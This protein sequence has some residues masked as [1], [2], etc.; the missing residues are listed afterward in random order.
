MLSACSLAPHYHTPAM[1][2]VPAYKEAGDWIVAQ[3][4][5]DAPR[6]QWWK[7][8]GN[9]ELNVLEDKLATSN[10]DIKI[11]LARYEEA[12]SLAKQAQ[13]DFF[14]TVTADGHDF[15][16]RSSP[17]FTTLH[18]GP[19]YNDY[20]PSVDLSYEIDLWGRIR[21]EVY[22]QNSLAKASFADAAAAELSV[23][24]ELATDYFMLRG[25]DASQRVLDETVVAYSKALDLTRNRFKG[26]V[27]AEADLDQAETQYQNARTQDADMHMKRQQLEHAIAVLIGE[28]PALF[29]L[30]TLALDD[31]KA[32]AVSPGLP[33][34][35]LQRRPDIAA[36]QRRV[37]AA[38][39]QIGVARAAWFPDFS[40]SASY[41]FESVKAS[42][43]LTSASRIWSFGPSMTLPIFEAGRISGLNDQARA[44]YDESVATYRK[45]VLTAY[46]DVEDSLVALRQLDQENESQTAATKAAERALKQ[47]QD[48][49]TG[50]IITYLDVVVLQNTELQARLSSIDITTR[51]MTQSVQLVK[52][53][54]GGWGVTA[55]LVKPVAVA[56]TAAPLSATPA[57][58]APAAPSR[59]QR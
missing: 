14:P 46:Q 13:A 4:A 17:N 28:P 9:P 12:R 10:Q 36:A 24:A 26:G 51:E 11:Y 34:T 54:G 48:R 56:A 45:T 33:S 53:L 23:R 8:F 38:N 40:L 43:L 22:A 25:D 35:L 42:N 6:G 41:G 27:A 37:Q 49:Y 47:A 29:S 39:A 32:P 58:A 21:N 7:A 31:L 30:P 20:L 19:P 1:P 59:A 50:G 52:A 44:Q 18:E 3:P 5:D 2:E 57:G 55:Q 16:E 15:R